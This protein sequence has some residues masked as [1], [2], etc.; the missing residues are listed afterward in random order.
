MSQNSSIS[1]S[2]KLRPGRFLVGLGI[3]V[4]VLLCASIVVSAIGIRQGLLTWHFTQLVNYQTEK[5]EHAA[6]AEVLLLGDSSLGN[7]VDVNEWSR[8]LDRPVVSLALTG[9]YGYA[10]ALSMLRLAL[11]RH[12]VE[13]VVL[14]FTPDMMTRSVS[15]QGLVLTAN[16]YRDF[17][18][19]PPTAV[20]NTLSSLDMPVNM[21]ITAIR[22]PESST[23]DYKTNDYVPQGPSLRTKLN[24]PP[25]GT[26][27]VSEI[28]ADKTYYLRRIAELCMSQGIDCMYAHGPL[29]ESQCLGSPEYLTAVNE[30]IRLAGIDVVGI[31]PKC[32]PW[33][34]IGDAVDHVAPE[35][36][37][38]LSKQ[39]FESLRH[40][41]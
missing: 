1:S 33:G 35:T 9:V 30:R 15:H 7:S 22:Q 38:T 10:G 5:L 32:I 17:F 3:T 31:T 40:R 34:Q 24:A 26:F 23:P 18:D 6:G 11:Q 29:V 13:T 28:V 4:A 36:K 27:S 37:S 19:A 8:E 41:L 20:W 16:S 14:V 12:D 25:D 21:A 39:L 2:S